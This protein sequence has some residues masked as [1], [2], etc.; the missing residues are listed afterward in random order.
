MLKILAV[1]IL[2]SGCSSQYPCMDNDISRVDG[3]TV[4]SG[5]YEM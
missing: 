1:L 4:K 2:L 5:C 3:E